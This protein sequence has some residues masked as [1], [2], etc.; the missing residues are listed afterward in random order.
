MKKNVLK[1]VLPIICTAT[2]LAGCGEAS[3]NA[4]SA[5]ENTEM[6]GVDPSPMSEVDESSI[7]SAAPVEPAPVEPAPV[8]LDA[9]SE[10]SATS[11][12]EY[13][14]ISKVTYDTLFSI[15]DKNELKDFAFDYLKDNSWQYKNFCEC[16][17]YEIKYMGSVFLSYGVPETENYVNTL[18]YYFRSKYT[19]DGI[20][21]CRIDFVYAHNLTLKED[22]KFEDIQFNTGMDLN[23]FGGPYGF[24]YDDDEFAVQMNKDN[25]KENYLY[26][27]AGHIFEPDNINLYKDQREFMQA[28]SDGTITKEYVTEAETEEYSPFFEGLQ[29]Q[30]EEGIKEVM[31]IYYPELTDKNTGT[32][33]QN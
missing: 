33:S 9:G 14:S 7:D 24:P 29:P 12:G 13:P 4:V 26:E 22:G 15:I 5:K 27:M 8:T 17:N 32:F 16:E 21:R 18:G 1:S 6:T 2:L 19:E 30:Y 20:D 23:S 28:F 25:L 11:E 10:E 3:A 31:S